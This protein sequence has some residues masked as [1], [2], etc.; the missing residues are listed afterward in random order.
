MMVGWRPL[1]AATA[2]ALFG[3]A[4]TLSA[5]DPRKAITQYTMDTWQAENGL[6][7]NSVM[8][9]MQ[10]RDGY[11]WLGTEEG[12]VRFDGV[13]FTVFDPSNTSY[14][15]HPRVRTAYQDRHGDIWIGTLGGGISV[16][17]NGVGAQAPNEGLATD[18]IYFFHED[19]NGDL[20]AGTGQGL[21]RLHDGKW[22]VF[23]G[24]SEPRAL[25]LANDVVGFWEDADGTMWLGTATGLVRYQNG[26]VTIFGKR[27]GLTDP[28][29]HTVLRDRSGT[30]WVGTDGGLARMTGNRFQMLRGSSGSADAPAGKIVFSLLED[31]DGNLWIATANGLSRYRDGRFEHLT[32]Q[33]GLPDEIVLTL[34]EDREGILW[35]GL[36]SG[37]LLRLRDA[38]F[39]A[40][41]P[42]EGLSHNITWSVTQDSEGAMWV[43]THKGLNR[44]KDGKIRVYT[45]ADGLAEDAVG[46]VL[47]D[48]KGNVWAGTGHGLSRLHNG[49]W[50]TF[51]QSDGLA[52]DSVMALF[53]DNHGVV[54]IGTHG[55][56]SRF[57][58]EHFL[59]NYTTADGLVNNLA[60]SIYQDH[61][62]R[63][64]IGTPTG[65]CEQ[66][67]SRFVCHGPADGLA[68][69]M[70]LAMYEDREGVLWIGTANGLTRY[71][72][73]RFSSFTQ[74]DGLFSDAILTIQEDRRGRLW[75]GSNKGV[76]FVEKQ[77]FDEMQTGHRS[78]LEPVSYGKS[79]GMKIAECDGGFQPAGWKSSDGRL[80]FP[81]LRGVVVTDPGRDS[82][83]PR[84]LLTGIQ[85]NHH[86]VTPNEIADLGGG[87][88]EFHYAA[89]TFQTPEHV[90]YRYRLE[91][92]DPDWV[93]A[94]SRRE[95]FYTLVPPG[96]YRFFVAA[97]S[98]EGVWNP[99]P[100]E[101]HILLRPHFYQTRLFQ[102]LVG[103]L[104]VTLGPV[105][106]YLRVHALQIRQ[107]ELETLVEERT[108]QLRAAN[109]EL[110]R[111]STTDDLTGIANHRQFAEFL[112]QEWRRAHRG[113]FP[114]T[115]L[116]LDVD[117]FKKYNDTHGHP[118]GD[119]CLRKVASIL[120]E[121]ANRPTDLA[122]RYGGEEFAI[123]LSDTPLEG[124]LQMAERVRAAVAQLG[125]PPVTI[126]IGAASMTPDESNDA[127]QLIAAAD[128][129]LYRAKQEG[130]NRV[131]SS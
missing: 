100:A 126:S 97:A 5:L 88:V 8:S 125:D 4:L 131:V 42:T 99:N 109:Q 67:G 81:T 6:P 53:E 91:G 18:Q 73:G 119:E 1:L 103:L 22:Q 20:L 89:L 9:I 79:D 77:Q 72:G 36:N 117:H 74:R 35:A 120:K 64:W 116:M 108:V 60:R 65:L 107:R 83:A 101:V 55:G 59:P 29:V 78:I 2:G 44:L 76:F 61:T 11:L 82:A 19:K 33:N 102:V 113:Q 106:Y 69:P 96:R 75:M 26:H 57:S 41:T 68:G 121:S 112:D 28:S 128:A 118:A 92:V 3:F 87:D 110:L 85:V 98:H 12:L 66:R 95:A 13:Q 123:V 49:A 24:E 45:A 127:S 15:I 16:L 124:A 94:G 111:L 37:G 7:Q 90:H 47:G 104:I 130:R 114:I 54:W 17:R 25:D 48:S 50:H 62:G 80:W 14:L 63:M 21:Y 129:C 84:V 86:P 93:E 51:K 122:A 39:T 27:D 46:A 43:A 70:V 56:V 40:Y 52:N 31:R 30:L 10:S 38:R 34:F 71:K 23:P 115:L 32:T 58:D 105:I